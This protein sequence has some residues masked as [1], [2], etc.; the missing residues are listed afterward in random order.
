MMQVFI[1][2]IDGFVGA[3]VGEELSSLGYKVYGTVFRRDPMHDQEFYLDITRPETFENLPDQS[4][5][6]VIHNAGMVDQNVPKS[7]MYAVNVGGTRNVLTWAKKNNCKHFIQISSSSVYGLKTMGQNLHENTKGVLTKFGA[8][9]QLSKAKAERLVRNSELSFTILRLPPIIGKNDTVTSRVLIDK[10]N[11]QS[12][13]RIGSHNPL[14]SIIAVKALPYMINQIIN[15]DI[16]NDAYNCVSHQ[17]KWFDLVEEYARLLEKPVPNTRKPL[18]SILW[19]LDDKDF[20]FLAVYSRFGSHLPNDKF[21][22]TFGN[23][24]LQSWK[25]AVFEAVGV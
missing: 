9:Y 10:L 3:V 18:S 5:D 12:F 13:F 1:T 4:Y 15:C 23:L 19:N 6:V 14:V 25:K 24:E 2:G 7:L 11:N 16:T 20:L 22:Q 21:L 17:V 8:P